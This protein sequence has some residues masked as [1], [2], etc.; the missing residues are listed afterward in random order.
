[1]RQD[2]VAIWLDWIHY[3]KLDCKVSITPWILNIVLPSSPNNSTTQDLSPT[4]FELTHPQ[5]SS[6]CLYSSQHFCLGASNVHLAKVPKW[7]R[8]H[9]SWKSQL[10][11]EKPSVR[12]SNML[13]IQ[14]GEVI[15]A[16]LMWKWCVLIFRWFCGLF[17]MSD[18]FQQVSNVL[19][20]SDL[21]HNISFKLRSQHLSMAI[22]PFAKI[23]K[24]DQTRWSFHLKLGRSV[25]W[26][27]ATMYVK[28]CCFPGVMF[29]MTGQ[30]SVL[31]QVLALLRPPF[32]LPLQISVSFLFLSGIGTQGKRLVYGR[33]R[34]I[35]HAV[36]IYYHDHHET[37]D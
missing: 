2:F 15:L 16:N 6:L 30:K 21:T 23:L 9:D 33:Q 18:M 1:M 19:P 26:R 22:L 11:Q 37:A 12:N 4:L 14:F 24:R 7:I 34:L 5:R 10:V 13:E 36:I 27:L 25:P 32:P 20:F 3:E 29:T 31:L 28:S 8:Q 35:N 17:C